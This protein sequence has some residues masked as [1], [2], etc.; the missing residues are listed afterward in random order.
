MRPA[1]L[2][3]LT[4]LAFLAALPA[5]AQQFA[6][7]GKQE[8][9]VCPVTQTE[10]GRAAVAAQC[11]DLKAPN[12][13]GASFRSIADLETAR[14]EREAFTSQVSAYGRCVTAFINAYRRPG[15]PADSTAPDEAACA[16]A[17]AEDQATETV[18][19]YGR[20]CIDYSNRSMIDRKLSLWS[21]ACYP[22]ASGTPG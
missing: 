11:G 12:F 19:A 15:A 16:H 10:R 14:L 6:G 2:A 4:A 20:A 17:W 21:G 18:R 7:L 22:A 5:S 13:A 3:A 8:Y 1:P 9:R